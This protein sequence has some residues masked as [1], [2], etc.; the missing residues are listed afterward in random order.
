MRKVYSE[1]SSQYDN[2]VKKYKTLPKADMLEKAEVLLQDM[3]E[4]GRTVSD[5][6]Y[7]NIGCVP[8]LT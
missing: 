6:P 8:P 7:R 3:R 1:I 4:A 2:F 5:P